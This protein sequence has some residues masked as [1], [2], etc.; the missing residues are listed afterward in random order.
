MTLTPRQ[1]NGLE[2][3][4]NQIKCTFSMTKKSATHQHKSVKLNIVPFKE[5]TDSVQ[6][7]EIYMPEYIDNAGNMRSVIIGVNDKGEYAFGVRNK[8]GN[9]FRTIPY[10]ALQNLFWGSNPKDDKTALENLK[11]IRENNG[12]VSMQPLT[13]EVREENWNKHI[14]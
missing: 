14:K 12:V 7:I 11:T 4:I 8:Y 2:K 9:G 3:L 6:V 5:D 13:D 10:S 1:K